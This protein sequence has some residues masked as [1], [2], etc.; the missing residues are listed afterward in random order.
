MFYLFSSDSTSRYKTDILDVLCYPAGHIFRFR[1]QD[2]YVS[3]EVKKR[4]TEKKPLKSEKGIVVYAE[5]QSKG[6]YRQFCFYPVRQVTIERVFVQGSIYYV[7]FRVGAFIDYGRGENKRKKQ[8]EYQQQMKK[9]SYHPTPLL[10]EKDGRRWGKVW[11][12]ASKTL[13]DYDESQTGKQLEHGYYFTYETENSLGETL[14][15]DPLAWESVVDVL[16][17]SPTMKS[18]LFFL[19]T[20]FFRVKRAWK[21][22]SYRETP[23]EGFDDGWNT[24]YP[25]PMGKTVVLKLLFYRPEDSP[26]IYPQ[27]LAINVDRDVLAGI[28]QQEILVHSHYNEER[29]ELA[30][31]RVYDSVLSALS[32]EYKPSNSAGHEE[33]LAPHP[34]FLIKVTVPGDRKSVV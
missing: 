17:H 1:Y 31:K 16:S 15:T 23:I 26:N 29:V 27:K 7:D 33:V 8:V 11:D 34:F 18:C 2:H 20:G 28:S 12:V 5:H 25:L 9:L 3:E 19:T 30:F 4:T 24:K 21:I 13:V 22:G 10:E 6:A 32:I 14:G